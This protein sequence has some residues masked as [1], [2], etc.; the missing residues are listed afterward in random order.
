MA[1]TAS[2]IP[3]DTRRPPP[4]EDFTAEQ[5]EIWRATVATMPVGWFGRETY[6]ILAS[7]CR[8]VCRGRWLADKINTGQDKLRKPRTACTCSTSSSA[9]QSEKP[10]QCSL[11]LEPYG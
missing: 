10:E 9:W 4:P 7:Y 6:Q 8:H 11:T 5:A 3:L 2:I 1:R